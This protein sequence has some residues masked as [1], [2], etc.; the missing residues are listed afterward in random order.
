MVRNKELYPLETYLDYAD[1]VLERDAG[2]LETFVA[3]MTDKDDG[4]RWWSVVGLH[5]LEKDAA[6][7]TDVLESALTDESEE[8]QIMAAWTLIKLGKEEEGLACLR[9]LLFN[10]TKCKLLLQ[11]TIDW[12]GAPAFPLV[13]E[14]IAAKPEKAKAGNKVSILGHIM[15]VNRR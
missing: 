5:L 10:G 7:A 3:G 4:I 1:K 13:K 9:D 12:V 8:V 14:Y 6:S 15:E 2:H 11:N